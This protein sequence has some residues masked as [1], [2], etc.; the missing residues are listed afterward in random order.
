[1]VKDTKRKIK[2]IKKDK[3]WRGEFQ[4]WTCGETY[5]SNN[6]LVLEVELMSYAF[7]VKGGPTFNTF[8]IFCVSLCNLCSQ[9]WTPC[10]TNIVFIAL[11]HWYLMASAQAPL[12]YSLLLNTFIWGNSFIPIASVILTGGW[13]SHWLYLP[14]PSPGLWSPYN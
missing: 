12:L 1:M 9:I 13:N 11:K 10:L 3:N 14:V 4:D 8:L 7:S 6:S 5:L 2:L